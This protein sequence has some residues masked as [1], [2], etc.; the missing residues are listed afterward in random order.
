[1]KLI[2]SQLNLR[3]RRRAT[4][5]R[6]GSPDKI[7]EPSAPRWRVYAL[8]AAVIL[9]WGANWPIMKVGLAYIPPLTFGAARLALGSLCLFGVLFLSGGLRRPGPGDL[10][11]ILS[12]SILHMA[13]PLALMNLALLHV[14]AGRSSVL[15]FTTPLWVVPLAIFCMG[16]RLGPIQLFGVVVGLAG[17]LVLFGPSALAWSDIDAVI[18][19][20]LLLVSALTWAVAILIAR[21]QNWR[22]TPL[23]LAPWQML[24]ASLILA[25]PAIRYESFSAIRWG[26]E[27]I[28]VL[29]FNGP[30]ASAFC[31]WGALVVAKELPPVV[32]SMGFLGV[33]VAGVIFSAVTLHE[34][35]THALVSGLC[36]IVMGIYLVDRGARGAAEG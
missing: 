14:G 34:P 26:G 25:I 9:F 8:F 22:S 11:I 10:R 36:L 12:E 4:V 30:V 29:A 6:I 27:L 20:G 3:F 35:L 23:Q 5:T 17:I 1:M 19:N 31:F 15:S 13:A 28:A 24:L 2:S 32:T 7:V 16:E 33:P 18:G 21:T